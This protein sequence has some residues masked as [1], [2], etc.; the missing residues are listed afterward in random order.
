MQRAKLILQNE[1]QRFV[2]PPDLVAEPTEFDVYKQLWKTLEQKHKKKFESDYI[3]SKNKRQSEENQQQQKRNRDKNFIYTEV[4]RYIPIFEINSKNSHN[5]KCSYK[6]K[7]QCK[8][9]QETRHPNSKTVH[10]IVG[11]LI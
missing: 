5:S 1:L 8:C 9:I 3:T 11:M 2:I 10:Y 4:P 6:C 7:C